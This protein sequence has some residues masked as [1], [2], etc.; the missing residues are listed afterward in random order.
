[1]GLRDYFDIG[2]EDDHA[3]LA[4]AVGIIAFAVLVVAIAMVGVIGGSDGRPLQARAEQPL[5]GATVTN[6]QGVTGEVS[7]TAFA[8]PDDPGTTLETDEEGRVVNP[9][10]ILTPEAVG[11]TGMGFRKPAET[12]MDGRDTCLYD[13]PGD[14]DTTRQVTAQFTTAERLKRENTT[15][16]QWLYRYGGGGGLR[17]L[18]DYGDETVEALDYAGS[19]AFFTQKG[20]ALGQLVVSKSLMSRSQAL[21]LLRDTLDHM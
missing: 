18:P 11:S 15:P 14:E 12:Q 8:P 16:R 3:T 2:G 10:E 5:P 6:A 17:P 9:C 21:M 4:V 20:D 7:T 13:L 19:W 1:M